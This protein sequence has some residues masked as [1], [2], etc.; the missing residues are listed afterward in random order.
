[1]QESTFNVCEREL[2]LGFIDPFLAMVASAGADLKLGESA[3]DDESVTSGN[4]SDL[5]D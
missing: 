3:A 4:G 5:G 2:P 1:M